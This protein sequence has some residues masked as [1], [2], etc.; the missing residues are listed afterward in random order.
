MLFDIPIKTE[1]LVIRKFIE[2]D[3]DNLYEMHT[4]PEVMEFVGGPIPGTRQE[5]WT[6]HKKVM[7]TGEDNDYGDLAVALG[8]TNEFLGWI[9]VHPD[10]YVYGI[11]LGFRFRKQIW[12]KGYAF[13]AG[14]AVARACFKQA[15]L[16]RLVST[17]NLENKR[18]INLFGK[19]GFKDTG[20]IQVDIVA[21][22][23][24]VFVLKKR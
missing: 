12:G 17:V 9:G 4:D 11:H 24:R 23:L 16:D 14:K 19:I 2:G 18:M 20:I 8:S 22:Y 21:K 13:E 1:K 3:F 6:H 10:K 15:G 5:A 7:K